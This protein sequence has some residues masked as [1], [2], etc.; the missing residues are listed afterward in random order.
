M[1][2]GNA[3]AIVESFMHAIVEERL[4]DARSL[5]GDDFVAYEAG[6]LPYSGEYHSPQG[7]FDLLAKMTEGLEFTLGP[8]P[9]LLL[10]GD[11]VAVRSRVTF[12]ARATGKSV[13][14][15]L[16]EV[17]TVN[18]GLIAELDVYYQDPAAVAALLAG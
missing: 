1:T 3:L 9:Q 17:Y 11:S 2:T 8:A 5:L 4:D 10:D 15:K 13:E 18:D 6:G 14:V 7:F 16:V 12:T